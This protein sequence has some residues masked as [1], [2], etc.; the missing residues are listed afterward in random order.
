MNKKALT[1]ILA[2]IVI[3]MSA[4]G[5]G[6]A[7]GV[8]EESITYDAWLDKN[9]IFQ[10]QGNGKRLEGRCRYATLIHSISFLWNSPI[11]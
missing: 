2:G 10:C 9:M 8:Q 11:L 1:G 7:E 4:G 3:I 6:R 5:C